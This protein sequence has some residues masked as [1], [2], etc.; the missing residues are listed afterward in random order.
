MEE[1]KVYLEERLV[2]YLM[3]R[4]EEKGIG[5]NASVAEALK[6]LRK[7]DRKEER[8]RIKNDPRFYKE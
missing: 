5:I 7:K 6:M 1:L 4:K 2:N 3:K 8:E